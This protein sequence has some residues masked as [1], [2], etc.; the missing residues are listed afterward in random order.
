[1][2]N[3]GMLMIE[4]LNIE[5]YNYLLPENRIASHPLSERDASRLLLYNRGSISDKRFTELPSLVQS[6]AMMV[7]NNTRVVPARLLFAKESGAIIEIF[8]LEPV[9]PGDYNLSFAQTQSVVWRA[10]IGNKKRWKK[11]II[12]I[13]NPLH[14]FDTML[15]AEC[16]GEEEDTF[17][18]RFRWDGNLSFSAILEMCGQIPIPPY[19]C[20]K[21]EII[22]SERYQ[23]IYAALRG[24]VA[25]PTAGLHFSTNVITSL[26]DNKILL[27]EITLHVG[28]GTFMPVKTEMVVRHQMHSEPFEVSLS[29]L[30]HL[31]SHK[32]DIIAVG[33]T[34]VR[35]LESLYYFG[36]MCFLG[37]EPLFLSQWDAYELKPVLTPKESLEELIAYMYKRQLTHFSARTQI[38]IVPSFIFHWTNGM[39]T[40]FHQPKSTLLLLIAAFIGEDWRKCYQYA[41]DNGYRFLSYGDSSLLFPCS[42]LV[43]TG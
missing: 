21:P 17:L 9:E 1:M 2:Y 23:T 40:N 14:Q 16:I 30:E 8:C 3:K 24:S 37:R 4:S 10:I 7:F 38:M 42:D 26:K 28:A 19:L 5:N 27:S 18:V 20:R 22:D 29:F 36:L 39:I 6:G 33:T 35:C 32:G 34:S 31:L 13:Y 43:K 15:S 12:Y 25:A 11:G 41:L